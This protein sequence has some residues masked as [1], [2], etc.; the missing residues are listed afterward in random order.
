VRVRTENPP[1]YLRNVIR[2]R[3]LP[4]K[5][6]KKIDKKLKIKY[7]RPSPKALGAI[8]HEPSTIDCSAINHQPNKPSTIRR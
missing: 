7:L 5:Q 8:H 1:D 6:L 2:Q 3:N 4:K